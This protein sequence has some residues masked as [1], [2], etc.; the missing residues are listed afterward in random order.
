MKYITDT[1]NNILWVEKSE[2]EYN[3]ERGFQN[4]LNCA[5]YALCLSAMG[6]A[7]LGLV[8]Y[9]VGSILVEALR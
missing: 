5:F 1:Q 3:A 6:L 7:V 4:F 8:L 2:E 9:I